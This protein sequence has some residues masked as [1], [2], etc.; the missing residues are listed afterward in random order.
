REQV[1]LDRPQQL[2]EGSVGLRRRQADRGVGLVD[3]AVGGDA[4]RVFWDAR[5]AEQPGGAVVSG[6]RVDLHAAS[7]KDATTVAR[8]PAA[9]SAL[10]GAKWLR[11]TYPS[12]MDPCRGETATVVSQ[13]TSLPSVVKGVDAAAGAE[14]RRRR[15]AL[16]TLPP[17]PSRRAITSWPT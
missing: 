7:S 14:R 3:V 17:R 15:S 2:R 11:C 16:F 12:A 4:R 10:P 1:A 8:A 9:S 6:A 5:A 13:P